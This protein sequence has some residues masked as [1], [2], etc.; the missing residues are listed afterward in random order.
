M[1]KGRRRMSCD[2][3]PIRQKNRNLIRKKIV[4][5][6]ME[7]QEV[8]PAARKGPIL[9]GGDLVKGKGLKIWGGGGGRVFVVLGGG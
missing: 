5:T 1:E 3:L 6:Y 4:L 7:G 2:M 8:G 9:S